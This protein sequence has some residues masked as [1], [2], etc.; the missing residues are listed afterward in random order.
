[1]NQ[2]NKFPRYAALA[3]A[4]FGRQ[5]TAVLTV[6]SEG[7]SAEAPRSEEIYFLDAY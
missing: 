2:G 7:R 5:N 3:G 6:S 4:S 1:M